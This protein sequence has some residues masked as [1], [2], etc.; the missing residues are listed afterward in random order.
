VGGRWDRAVLG[1]KP[2][3]E[4]ITRQADFN[5]HVSGSS[6]VL[7]MSVQHGQQTDQFQC[8]VGSWMLY[9]TGRFMLTNALHYLGIRPRPTG[10]IRGTTVVA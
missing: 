10:I 2:R 7:N 4:R 5:C 9:A 3:V 6:S 1:F 8:I